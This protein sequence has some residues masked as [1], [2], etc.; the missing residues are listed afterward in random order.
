MDAASEGTNE[1]SNSGVGY[2]PV[3]DKNL[4]VSNGKGERCGIIMWNT[5]FDCYI[6]EPEY[7]MV[8]GPA[9][10][11]NLTSYMIEFEA[12]RRKKGEQT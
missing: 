9:F 11:A 8:F 12:K 2:F 7:G 5:F 3:I 10:L 6:F 4:I 1:G